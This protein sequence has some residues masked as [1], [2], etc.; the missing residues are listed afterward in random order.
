M[1]HEKN[2]YTCSFLTSI[3]TTLVYEMSSQ[4]F[5]M[6]LF[7]SPKHLG[8]NINT[9]EEFVRKEKLPFFTAPKSQISKFLI[10]DVQNPVDCNIHLSY[11]NYC[12]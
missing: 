10:K 2:C 12:F 3:Q 6:N 1:E 9:S 7:F 5:S 11:D 8:N 4:D